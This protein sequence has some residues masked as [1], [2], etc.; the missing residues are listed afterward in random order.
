M[1]DM[2]E[3][4]MGHA[5]F[6]MDVG[7]EADTRAER[8]KR[9]IGIYQASISELMQNS[10]NRMRSQIG[11][12]DKNKDKNKE[13]V[14]DDSKIITGSSPVPEWLKRQFKDMDGKVVTGFSPIP[15]WLKRQFKDMD[16]AKKEAL[17]TEVPVVDW[18]DEFNTNVRNVK[19][20]PKHHDPDEWNEQQKASMKAK[21]F[22]QDQ[23]TGRWH[24]PK[25]EPR[26][27]F[28]WGDESLWEWVGNPLPKDTIDRTMPGFTFSNL[29]KSD[30]EVR[31]K[32]SDDWRL[33]GDTELN[34]DPLIDVINTGRPLLQDIQSNS[35]NT[36]FEIIKGGR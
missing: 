8:D 7:K 9:Q 16:V 4:L 29:F 21:G 20:M 13:K 12:R 23:S 22:W 2:Y 28:T 3:K 24:N 11:D 5:K 27:L 18:T 1:A 35:R 36:L 14:V 25:G 32:R 33:K 15:N 26:P 30:K 34:Y 17:P 31:P 19:D 10:I 6:M